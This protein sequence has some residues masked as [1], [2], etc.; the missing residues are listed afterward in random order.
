MADTLRVGIIGIDAERGWA[1]EAHGPAVQAVAGLELAAVANRS[2]QAADDAALALGVD[3]AYGDPATLIGDA[4]IDIVTVAAPVPAHHDLIAAALRAGKHVLTEWPLGTSTAQSEQIAAAASGSNLH[5]AVGLQSRLNPAVVRALALIRSDTIGPVLT[6]TVYS[7]TAGFGP[8]VPEAQLYLEDPAT[9]MNLP[10]IQMAH[11]VD[12]AVHLAG[13]LRPVAALATVQYPQLAVGDPARPHTRTI[14]DHMLVHGRLAGGG[15]LAVQ[16]VGG[17]PADGT[18]FRMD[19]VGRDGTL[20][21]DGGAPRGFQAGLLGLCLDD[22]PVDIDSGQIGG[23]PDAVGNVACT[24]A[25]LRDDIHHGTRT[26]P[27]FD[28]AVRLAH[29]VDGIL[30]AA[31]NGQTA[32]ASTQWP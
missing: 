26:V 25:A 24:Y 17:R 28:H 2:Q 14:P 1:R 11:T 16:V 22:E 9:N 20:T 21:L 6:V 5:T 10:S 30:A 31:A 13:A 3:R 15:A 12:L 7:C 32:T 4:S 27:D 18:P 23:L 29:L 8:V 19:I